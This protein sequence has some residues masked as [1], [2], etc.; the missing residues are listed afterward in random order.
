MLRL[1]IKLIVKT[2]CSVHSDNLAFDLNVCIHNVFYIIDIV[3]NPF[4]T[5][6]FTIGKII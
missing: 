2:I 6:T 1:L 5:K 4:I 3:R